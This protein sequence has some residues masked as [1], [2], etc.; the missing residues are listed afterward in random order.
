MT[1]QIKH[2]EKAGKEAAT[3]SFAWTLPLDAVGRGSHSTV[4]RDVRRDHFT[5]LDYVE[6]V[7][8]AVEAGGFDAAFVPFD[9]TGDD[10]WIAGAAVARATRHLEVIVEYAP[11][12]GT[13]VYAAKMSATFQRFSHGRL[14]VK[15]VTGETPVLRATVAVPGE[16]P[17]QRV[18]E[19]LEIG[20]GL[21]TGTNYAYDG[22]VFEVAGSGLIPQLRTYPSPKVYLAGADERVVG[23][24][25]QL[26]DVH[27]WPLAHTDGIPARVAGL[28]A[29]AAELGRSVQSGLH[30]AVLARPSEEEARNALRLQATAAGFDE[31]EGE[32]M[33]GG[34]W[35]GFSR[36]GYGA[37]GGLVG[38]YRQVA[39]ALDRLVEMG[40]TSFVLE[41]HPHIEEAYRFAEFVR[42]ELGIELASAPLP[43]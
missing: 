20:R 33:D 2:S 35:T 4:A 21:W 11:T 34:V 12:Y 17:L 5:P 10:S 29:R 39:E 36:L 41:G 30:L 9:V 16:Q 43:L 15:P 18:Q 19:Y 27:L 22:Q 24:S 28:A 8:R 42:P 3:P 6:Q 23:V 13:P 7:A 32:K 40:V 14:A 37:T 31:R 25:A 38:S 26:A 1:Q